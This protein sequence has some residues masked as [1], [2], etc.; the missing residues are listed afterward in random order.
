MC[1]RVCVRVGNKCADDVRVSFRS[2]AMNLFVKYLRQHIQYTYYT[3]TQTTHVTIRIRM[4]SESVE[5]DRHQYLHL[6]YQ[7]RSLCEAD[8]TGKVHAF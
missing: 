8:D 1:A 6:A 7:R 4:A 2:P 5:A 3:Y